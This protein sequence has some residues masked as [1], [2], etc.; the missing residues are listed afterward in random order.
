MPRSSPKAIKRI[1]ANLP[2]DL[3]EEAMGVSHLNLT[4]TLIKGLELVKKGQA[5]SKAQELKGRLDLSIDLEVSR[6]RARR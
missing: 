2:E 3:L 6:E 4:E 5:G 1:T